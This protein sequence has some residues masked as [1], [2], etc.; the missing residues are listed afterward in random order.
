[1]HSSL[2]STK[3][4][5]LISMKSCSAAK[6]VLSLEIF[7]GHS[8]RIPQKSISWTTQAGTL[9]FFYISRYLRDKSF[10]LGKFGGTIPRKPPHIDPQKSICLNSLSW[11]ASFFDISRYLR[12]KYFDIVWGYHPLGTSQWIS[13]KSIL[14]RL[15]NMRSGKLFNGLAL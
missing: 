12:G 4:Q 14:I 7:W 13:Q 8:P 9:V 15:F 11:G 3:H 6:A 2:K 10:D 5:N 1:M